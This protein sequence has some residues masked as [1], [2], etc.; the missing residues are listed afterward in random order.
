MR[1]SIVRSLYLFQEGSALIQ[2]NGFEN[3]N[4]PKRSR[5]VHLFSRVIQRPFSSLA[6]LLALG[7][8]VFPLYQILLGITYFEP[9][10]YIDETTL[11]MLGILILRCVLVYK[12][13]T[14]LQAVSI[15]LVCGLS[16]VYTFEALYKWSFYIFPW[17]IPAAEMRAL[18]IQV[19]IALTGGVGFAFGRFRWSTGAK[20][21]TGIFGL[22][23]LFWLLIGFPQI[24]SDTLYLSPLIN[25]HLSHSLIYLLNRGIK[26]ALFLGFFSMVY[27]PSKQ[28]SK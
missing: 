25:I 6:G 8:I 11:V 2:S 24:F 13:D 20:I 18:V 28:I 26:M 12:R 21:F 15:A 1:N 16:F 4:R 14:D 5:F 19:G 3:S 17:A 22:G 9:L 27:S 23:W 7:M 10:D